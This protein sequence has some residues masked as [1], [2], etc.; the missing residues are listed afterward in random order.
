MKG[1]NRGRGRG[2]GR[3]KGR[4]RGRGRGR[5]RAS[6][7]GRGMPEAPGLVHSRIGLQE[8]LHDLEVL[9]LGEGVG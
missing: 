1:R 9:G 5:G 4:N 2:R 7:K 8:L 3:G 6:D